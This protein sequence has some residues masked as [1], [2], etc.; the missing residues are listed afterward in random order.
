MG[1]W[2]SIKD[3]FSG[4]DDATRIQELAAELS[5]YADRYENKT[6]VKG[7]S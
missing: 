5:R 4:K 3:A 7:E 2:S 1:F 6:A